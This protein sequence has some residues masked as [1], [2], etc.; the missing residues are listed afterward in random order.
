MKIN[1]KSRANMI[2]KQLH[3]IENKYEFILQKELDRML[4]TSIIYPI[5]KSEWDNFVVSQSKKHDP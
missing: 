1:L 4:T 2:K 5:N 3:K